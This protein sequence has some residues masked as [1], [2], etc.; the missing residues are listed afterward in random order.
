[1][2]RLSMFMY[3]FIAEVHSVEKN[4]RIGHTQQVYIFAENVA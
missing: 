3:V 1:M 2:T 4:L